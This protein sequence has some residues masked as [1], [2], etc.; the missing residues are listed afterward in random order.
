VINVRDYGATGAGAA[1]DAP[2]IQAAL[3]DGGWV[4]APAG[5]YRLATLP[6]RIHARTRLTLDPGATLLRDA[7]EVILTNGEPAAT[8]GGYTGRG[9]IIVEG[10]V[11]DVNAAGQPANSGAIAF[12][13]AENLTVRDLTVKDVPGWHAIEINSSKTVR[14]EGCRFAGFVDTGDRAFSEA[15]Q[16][17]ADTSAA[18]FPWFGPHDGTVCDGVTVAGCWFGA[19]GTPGTQPWP[20][21]VGSHNTSEPNRH[22]NV[23]VL[24]CVFDHLA[25]AAV[26][27]YYWDGAVIGDNIVL[28]A[29]GEGIAVKDNSRYVTVQRNLVFDTG[30]TG[31][32]VNTDC[33]QIRVSG[34]EVIGAGASAANTHY[35]IR[36]SAACSYLRVTGNTVRKRA[37]GNH[38]RYGLSLAAGTTGVQRYGN[39]L[40]SSGVTGSVEDASTSPVTAA[41]DAL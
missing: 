3:D 11:W 25:D 34:N 40:R 22:K 12:A 30:R 4:Y 6:L 8:A 20:R 18:A 2:A 26:Q 13:H 16:I 14:I 24:A 37:S 7:D 5:T 33:T 21:G 31:I 35:G 28:A 17:D 38:A 23:K 32:W 1:D 39:D 19:S 10:G 41:A 29:G 36:C 27:T 15:I 9:G